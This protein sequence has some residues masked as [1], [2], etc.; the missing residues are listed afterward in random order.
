MGTKKQADKAFALTSAATSLQSAVYEMY[1]TPIAQLADV[2]MP[3]N[4]KAYCVATV[5]GAAML[6]VDA[7][8]KH[9]NLLGVCNKA[10]GFTAQVVKDVKGVPTV[11]KAKPYC[12]GK[13]NHALRATRANGD[14][15]RKYV[16][17]TI[18]TM[19]GQFGLDMLA[20]VDTL[21]GLKVSKV[22]LDKHLAKW[23]AANA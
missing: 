4:Q 22:D 9:V 10:D 17:P 6:G 11:Q 1:G 5:L 12:E 18:V 23:E 21:Y 20:A 14:K 2:P 15:E 19:R 16:L 8:V 3:K 7:F 13:H